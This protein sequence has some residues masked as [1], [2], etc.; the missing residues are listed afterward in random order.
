MTGRYCQLD[1]GCDHQLTIDCVRVLCTHE[2]I[3]IYVAIHALASMPSAPRLSEARG[4]PM[5]PTG[6][7]GPMD[8]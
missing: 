8:V 3:Y 6:P 2:Y 1:N 7:T 4:G 5:E